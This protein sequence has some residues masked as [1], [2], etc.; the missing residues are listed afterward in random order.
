MIPKLLLF[1]LLCLTMTSCV[2]TRD[3]QTTRIELM[4]P[5]IFKIPENIR[6][7]AL[8][9]SIP[10]N[11]DNEPFRYYNTLIY[12]KNIFIDHESKA[13]ETDTTIKYRELSNST[14]D[15][16]AW[17]LKKEGYFGT[18]I[19]YHD[20][21]DH[22]NPSDK[23]PYNPEK[24]FQET[25]S[26]LCIFLNYINFDISKYKDFESATNNASLY[27]TIVYQK[28]T[29]SYNYKQIDSLTFDTAD[30]P[31]DIPSKIKLKIVVNNSARYLGQSFCSK[32]IPT[33]IQVDRMYYTSKN[34]NMIQAEKFALN[35]DWRKAAELWNLQTRSQNKKIAAK[36]SYNMALGCEMEGNQDAAID[37]LLRSRTILTKNNE[38]HK[39]N[40]QEYINI[41]TQRKKEIEKLNQQ[42]RK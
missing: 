10:K 15:A 13:F 33:W 32:L 8:I 35:N 27:W 26:D 3:V 14:L 41:L 24:L 39:A 36:A 12:E 40:C 42:V 28:D 37:W 4:K 38:D 21:L 9:N 31:H 11:D 17:A 1:I 30:F 25:K 19:N 6:T 34:Q 7:V 20:S 16:L 2:I 29:V 5:G 23:E 22:I 18:V